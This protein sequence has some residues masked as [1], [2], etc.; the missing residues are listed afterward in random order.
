MDKK[1]KQLY[2]LR[3]GEADDF[4]IQK[5][6]FKRELTE[7]GIQQINQV[8]N[9]I[10]ENNIKIDIVI[11]SPAERT[12]QSSK[13][14]RELLNLHDVEFNDCLYPCTKSCIYDT[15]TSIDDSVNSVLI[16][17]HNP[18]LSSFAQEYM[19]FNN[20]S[21]PTAGLINCSYETNSWV[22]FA[23]ADR[24]KNFVTSPK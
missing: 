20:V 16:I 19:D 15:I 1:R 5:D 11:S 3:H 2:L 6:D 12:K 8:S 23:L 21:L 22:E 24:R 18:G 10:K 4:F 9:F 7:N 14:V 17:G 13:L